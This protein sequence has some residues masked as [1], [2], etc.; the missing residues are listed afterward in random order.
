MSKEMQEL[1]KQW[2]SVI[3]TIH[4]NANVGLD[5][6]FIYLQYIILYINNIQYYIYNIIIFIIYNLYSFH[7]YQDII[8]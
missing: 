6:N 2:H 1:Q 7:N 4:S 8:P 5:C 3:Q